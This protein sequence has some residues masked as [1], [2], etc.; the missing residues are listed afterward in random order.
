MQIKVQRIVCRNKYHFT[1][2]FEGIIHTR[3]F[4]TGQG[5]ECFKTQ[6]FTTGSVSVIKYK[7]PTQL[8]PY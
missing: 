7:A 4:D 3:I 2:Y 5:L 8:H 1:A 6:H